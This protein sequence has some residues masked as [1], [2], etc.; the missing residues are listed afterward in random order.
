MWEDTGLDQQGKSIRYPVDN[1]FMVF[2]S[3]LVLVDRA[4][5][6]V[7]LEQLKIFSV[8]SE[9]LACAK[10]LADELGLGG[11][12]DLFLVK[13]EKKAKT[14]CLKG[15]WPVIFQ[16]NCLVRGIFFK[17]HGEKESRSVRRTGRRLLMI[18]GRLRPA[19]YYSQER[20]E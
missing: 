1:K 6:E 17:V 15:K 10:L 5:V 13:I 8:Q 16:I 20:L 2:D 9:R 18:E 7:Q 3:V 14:L 19:T 12:H 4:I 11:D